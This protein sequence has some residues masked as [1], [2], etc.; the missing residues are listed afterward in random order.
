MPAGEWWRGWADLCISRPDKA[1]SPASL[2]DRQKPTGIRPL[3]NPAV[4]S[5]QHNPPDPRPRLDPTFLN[6]HLL[7]PRQGEFVAADPFG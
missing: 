1:Q 6:C 7:A 3:H 4:Q 2:S 5:A